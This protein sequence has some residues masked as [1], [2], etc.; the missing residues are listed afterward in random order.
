MKKLTKTILVSSFA[1][2]AA[3]ICGCRGSDVVIYD[4]DADKIVWGSIGTDSTWREAFAGV[5]D[6]KNECFHTL[7]DLKPA[8]GKEDGLYVL[9]E[10]DFSGVLRWERKLEGHLQV[11]PSGFIVSGGGTE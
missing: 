6:P 3:A 9:R 7:Q 5:V 2:A 4:G 1:L 11:S 10:Y 8:N